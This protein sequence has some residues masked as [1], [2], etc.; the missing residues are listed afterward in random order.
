MIPNDNLEYYGIDF[1]ESQITCAKKII[2]EKKIN[3]R[4]FRGNVSK[5]D[6]NIFKD[7]MFD[8]GLFIATL[9]C[10][11][12]KNKRLN[13]LKEFYRIL[14][15]GSLALISVWNSEDKR[16]DK[17][18]NKGNIYMSWKKD[19]IEHMRYYY[20]YSKEE[21]L[22]LLKKVGFKVLE[23]YEKKDN[24]DRFSRKNWI[25]RVGK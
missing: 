2:K 16:F 6:K 7:E 10:L 11:E 22:D 8:Y 14:K 9:H 18:G 13:S 12:T 25:V 3:A 19:G 21:F 15:R 20:L 24:N 4:L 5:L 1:S 23:F 17:V